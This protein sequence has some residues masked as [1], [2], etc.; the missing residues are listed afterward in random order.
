MN[1]N[2]I[3]GKC[4]K[5]KKKYNF[6]KTFFSLLFLCSFQQCKLFF[7]KFFHILEIRRS[8]YH[9]GGLYYPTFPYKEAMCNVLAPTFH[10]ELAIRLR[11][12][13]RKGNFFVQC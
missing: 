13:M 12:T 8:P 2:I 9:L 10:S 1:K 4:K 11:S 6:T 7:V 5:I 3:F